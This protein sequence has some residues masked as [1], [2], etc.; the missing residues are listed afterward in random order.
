MPSAPSATAEDF[1]RDAVR[2]HDSKDYAGAIQSL[3][4]ALEL[5]PGWLLAITTRADNQYHVRRY[6]EAIEQ[7]LRWN[8]AGNREC[9]ALKARREAPT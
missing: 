6:D 7:L 5:R 9:A 8:H 2:Q 4:R 1:Y 3:D